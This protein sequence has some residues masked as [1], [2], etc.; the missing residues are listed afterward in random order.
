M[1]SADTVSSFGVS[2]FGVVGGG[3]VVGLGGTVAEIQ[4]W[5]FVIGAIVVA[6]KKTPG[7]KGGGSVV[8]EAWLSWDW[9]SLDATKL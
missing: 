5:V 3:T 4:N 9:D 2:G 8:A 1:A 6:T 7:G